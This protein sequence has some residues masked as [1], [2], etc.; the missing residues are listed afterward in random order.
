MAKK[1]TFELPMVRRMLLSLGLWAFFGLLCAYFAASG[2]T[3]PN[4]WGSAVMWSIFFNRL[5]L[6]FLVALVWF[7]VVHPILKIRMYPICRWACAWFFIS[8]SL[9]FGAGDTKIF[10]ATVISGMVYGAI[11][12]L[13]ASKIAWEWRELLEW[14]EK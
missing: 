6:W 7:I 10:W 9:A 1:S 8:L 2:S 13:V 14:T 4:F 12:D 3:D 11:I 5:V